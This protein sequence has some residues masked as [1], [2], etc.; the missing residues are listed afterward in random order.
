[1]STVQHQSVSK[2]NMYYKY[3]TENV[4]VVHTSGYNFAGVKNI[5]HFSPSVIQ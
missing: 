3:A 2:I 5:A 4:S 1:M